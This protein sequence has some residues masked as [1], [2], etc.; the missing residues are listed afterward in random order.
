VK[1]PSFG[2]LT[3]GGMLSLIFGS[4][5]LIDSTSPELQVSLGVVVPVVLGF[6]AIAAFLVRLGL[7]AQRRPAVT[8]MEGMLNERGEAMTAIQ[9]GAP[10]RVNVHGETWRAISNEPIA[11]GERVH[12]AGLDGLTLTVRKE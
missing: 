6:T 5:M 3:V 1:V 7:A 9:P 8:G 2:L 12:V 10:G 11:A 4:M